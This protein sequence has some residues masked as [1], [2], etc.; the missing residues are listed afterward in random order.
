[1]FSSV[2]CFAC[3]G[4]GDRFG[5]CFCGV[6]RGRRSRGAT[7]TWHMPCNLPNWQVLFTGHDGAVKVMLV[8]R[9]YLALLFQ[10]GQT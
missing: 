3:E 4:A 2:I 1:M 7:T 6:G 5:H 9:T 10:T 8:Y